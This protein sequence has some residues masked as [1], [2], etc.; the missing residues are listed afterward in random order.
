MNP[1]QDVID[2]NVSEYLNIEEDNTNNKSEYKAE[3]VQFYP[4][5]P[6]DPTA[7]LCNIMLKPFN[8]TK[9]MISEENDL[10]TDNMIV[11][12]RYDLDKEPGWRWVPLRVRYDKTADFLQ[13]N[14]N[15]GNAYHVANSNWQTI[16]NPI[17]EDMIYTGLNIPN[18]FVNDDV[19]YNSVV[20]VSKT[21]SLRD[22]HNLYVKK[23]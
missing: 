16:N 5:N 21:R 20:G 12:F 18:M 2:D 6:Y 7:G 9:E 22:F 14:S 23:H 4:T 13:H 11:E 19:Y 10:I 3:P 15:F 1:C 17:T 8:N